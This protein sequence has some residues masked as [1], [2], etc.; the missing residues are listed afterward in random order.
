MDYPKILLLRVK[1]DEKGD[2]DFSKESGFQIFDST[3][4][5]LDY[6][7]S[8]EDKNTYRFMGFTFIDAVEII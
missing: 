5:T 1:K 2:M 6:I 8:L 3:K 4:K 7:D